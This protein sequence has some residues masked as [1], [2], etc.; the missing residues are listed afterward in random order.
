MGG[1]CAPRRALFERNGNW[2]RGRVLVCSLESRSSGVLVW[3]SEALRR[4]IWAEVSTI[5]ICR[6]KWGEGFAL[7]SFGLRFFALFCFVKTFARQS[8]I[9]VAHENS[10]RS[11]EARG[12]LLFGS[13]TQQ[14]GSN[15]SHWQADGTHLVE[16]L[17]ITSWHGSP[18]TEILSWISR[19]F[20]PKLL[21]S[22]VSKVPPSNGPLVGWIWSEA[23]VGVSLARVISWWWWWGGDD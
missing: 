4:E 22:I 19:S 3:D 21:P 18:P 23:M 10:N 11:Q 2:M 8:K 13:S 12:F 15:L 14:N 16:T 6:P 1:L 7:F 5:E 9:N 20:E 17:Y